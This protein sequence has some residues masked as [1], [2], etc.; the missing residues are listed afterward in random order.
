MGKA[1]SFNRKGGGDGGGGGGGGGR[2]FDHGG[3]GGG[4]SGGGP[5]RYYTQR[6]PRQHYPIS[7]GQQAKKKADFR[8]RDYNSHSNNGN[9]YAYRQRDG[10][11][12]PP[13][14]TH[15]KHGNLFD[16][17]PA[18]MKRLKK[19]EKRVGA[20]LIKALTP[21][22]PPD[23]PPP[24]SQ[25]DKRLGPDPLVVDECPW[26]A[27]PLP[28]PPSL[29]AQATDADPPSL[30]DELLAFQRYVSLTPTEMTG[31]AAV[32]G[33]LQRVIKSHWPEAQIAT[34]GSTAAS[35]ATFLSDV[36]VTVSG[37]RESKPNKGGSKGR[38]D[39]DK[40]GEVVVVAN[41]S[42]EKKKSERK[43]EAE[44][45]EEEAEEEEGE[46]EEEERGWGTAADGDEE[47]AEGEEEEEEEEDFAFNTL[48]GGGGGGGGGGEGGGGFNTTVM[49]RDIQRRD[50][51]V[52]Y[53]RL[54]EE[55]HAFIDVEFRPKARVPIIYTKHISGLEV[56]IRVAPPD[57]AAIS[58]LRQL[59]AMHPCFAPV[60]TALK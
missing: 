45:E 4:G 58:L 39:G 15:Q 20:A 35:L 17:M 51:Q 59:S 34:F 56:D 11:F 18:G 1:A 32:V 9:N 19:S 25:I 10:R 49:S 16:V 55:A 43:E 8:K 33:S 13:V 53:P 12:L 28:L 41:G 2:Y 38:R 36:D 57:H 5:K 60:A 6:P 23:P 21:A 44:E 26:L 14:K 7:A 24:W 46:E 48:V 31:R 40:E 30:H 50:L 37:F 29:P 3:G 22:L 27:S 42:E 54:I 47:E 52:L